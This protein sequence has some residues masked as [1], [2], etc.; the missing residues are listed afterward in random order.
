MTVYF[1]TLCDSSNFGS[2]FLLVISAKIRNVTG[3]GGLALIVIWDWVCQKRKEND[4]FHFGGIPLFCSLAKLNI[5]IDNTNVISYYKK[6]IIKN[7]S[8]FYV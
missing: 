6:K 4:S 3:F 5:I 7:N 1:L 8:V 2:Y